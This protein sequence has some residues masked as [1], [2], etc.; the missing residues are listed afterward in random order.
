MNYLI[1][2]AHPDDEVLGMGGTMYKLARSG[3]N[4]A[5]CILSG[6]VLARH[7]K[8][9]SD[10]LTQNLNDSASLIGVSRVITG[11]FP[12]IEFNNASHL[13][14]VQFIETAIIET[15]ADV[16]VTHHP[17]DTNND[18]LHTTLA[19]Q[20]AI[21]IFQRRSDVKPISEFM[22]MEVPSATDWS[23]NHAVE[24]F[25]PTTYFEIGEE[26]IDMKIK[27]LS[28]YEG[29]MRDFPHPR[30]AEVLKGLAAYRGGQSGFMYAEA[31][32]S[33]FRRIV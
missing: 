16:V 13:S 31:F 27:A 33:V 28:L 15:N 4:V 26:G 7:R 9:A 25:K 6:S 14:L 20:A 11:D 21:R 19:C 32:Q 24:M 17:A 1:V 8:P 22:F 10:V 12:N 3:N 5:V 2:A 18:H 30:S 23:V 29:V